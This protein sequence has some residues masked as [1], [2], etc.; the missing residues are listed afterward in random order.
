MFAP[1]ALSL[2]LHFETK[3]TYRYYVIYY[4][5]DYRELTNCS[6][7]YVI[8]KYVFPQLSH[9]MPQSPR[10]FSPY[11]LL[12]CASYVMVECSASSVDEREMADMKR[13]VMIPVAA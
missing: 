9:L 12:I 7:Y 3:Y 10:P 4:I 5:S 11:A 2:S 13:W 1:R 8:Y 6:I